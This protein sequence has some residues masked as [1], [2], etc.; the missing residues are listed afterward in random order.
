MTFHKSF[1]RKPKRCLHCG[2]FGHI[3]R[4][5]RELKIEK[6]YQKE[7]KEKSHKVATT[8]VKEDSSS[9]SSGLIVR[10]ALSASKSNEQHVW[11]I[12]S[13]ATSHMC[14]DKESFTTLNHLQTSID[15]VLGDGR[16]LKATGK[17]EIVLDSAQWE[18]KAC[19]LHNVLYCTKSFL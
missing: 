19:T 11:I 5:Y 4:F 14:R 3:K 1:K 9:E 8:A 2:K 17:G 10:H 6:E 16:A 18:S 13:G 15:V 12:D 7:R